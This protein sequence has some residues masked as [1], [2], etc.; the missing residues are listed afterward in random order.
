M[1]NKRIISALTALAIRNSFVLAQTLPLPRGKPEEVR[2]SSER[3]A[4]IGNA[5]NRDIEQSF[6]AKRALSGSA[7][8]WAAF[9]MREFSWPR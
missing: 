7:R 9:M 4:E 5:L 6:R 1:T 8:W 2:M 3:L